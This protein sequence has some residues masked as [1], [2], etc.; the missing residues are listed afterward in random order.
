MFHRHSVS[1][2]RLD[3]CV[4]VCSSFN[5]ILFHKRIFVFI[6]T[7][8]RRKHRT[9]L[10]SKAAAHL[11]RWINEFII[12]KC[13]IW[14]IKG[15]ETQFNE[16]S[17]NNNQ[18]TRLWCHYLWILINTQTKHYDNH[19]SH[20]SLFMHFVE[21]FTNAESLAWS[22]IREC[23]L[24]S[25]ILLILTHRFHRK[26]KFKILRHVKFKWDFNK[27]CS[28]VLVSFFQPHLCFLV[29]FTFCDIWSQ[30]IW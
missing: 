16:I 15:E 24:F 12:Q 25:H 20:K 13:I 17:T 22:A 18:K 9:L 3:V 4:C 7:Q 27:T 10:N 23:L 30:C 14:E 28:D 1:I 19:N 2:Q 5:A 21:L 29:R 8:W 6:L 26:Q 11:T